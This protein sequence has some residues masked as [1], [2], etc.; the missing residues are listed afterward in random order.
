MCLEVCF[1]RAVYAFAYTIRLA[2]LCVYAG[3][4][5]VLCMHHLRSFGVCVCLVV[6]D[7]P[8][9]TVRDNYD[10]CER[11]ESAPRPSGEPRKIMAK[12]VHP[13][14]TVTYVT[15]AGAAVPSE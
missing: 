6:H 2:F 14:P 8:R 5:C 4:C 3:L 15:A 10:L 12:I 13:D 1:A 11:C 9:C 7:V